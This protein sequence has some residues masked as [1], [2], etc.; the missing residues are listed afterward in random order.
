MSQITDFLPQLRERPEGVSESDAI[1][2]KY[3]FNPFA[4]LCDLFE[5][6]QDIV[7]KYMPTEIKTVEPVAAPTV[8]SAGCFDMGLVSAIHKLCNDEQFEAISELD[9]Y[10]TL[11]NVIG[12]FAPSKNGK[13]KSSV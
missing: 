2:K 10:A 9:L 4:S 5:T 12:N 3:H 8:P 6:F 13:V 11:N 7:E 1:A